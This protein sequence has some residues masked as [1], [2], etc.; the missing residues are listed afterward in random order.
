MAGNQPRQQTKSGQ[1]AGVEPGRVS[2]KAKC[3]GGV[4]RRESIPWAQGSWGIEV[5][6]EGEEKQGEE[7]EERGA[8]HCPRRPLCYGNAAVME[9]GDGASGAG[10]KGREE[11]ERVSAVP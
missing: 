4:E 2:P 5:E 9:G 3:K 11:M 8:A 10:R 7:A 6:E 1:G